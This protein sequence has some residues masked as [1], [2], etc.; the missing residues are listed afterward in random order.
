MRQQRQGAA[1]YSAPLGPSFLDAV[2]E[3]EAALAGEAAAA[4]LDMLRLRKPKA[5]MAI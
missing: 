3:E 5:T 1:A 2:A 4:G